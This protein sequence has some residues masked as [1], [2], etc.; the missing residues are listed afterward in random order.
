MRPLALLLLALLI[1]TGCHTVPPEPLVHLQRDDLELAI[2][3][4]GGGRA[5]S[6][7]LAGGANILFAT[8]ATGMQMPGHADRD[9]GAVEVARYSDDELVLIDDPRHDA[10]RGQGAPGPA[11]GWA[12]YGGHVTWVA[13]QRAWW[14]RV[15][16]RPP[17]ERAPIWPPDP[18]TVFGAYAIVEQHPHSLVL[19]GPASPITGLQLRKTYELLGDDRVRVSVVATNIGDAPVSWG[20]W[21]NTRLPAVARAFIPASPEAATAAD[22]GI[23]VATINGLC[24]LDTRGAR[25]GDSR[26][27]STS[28]RLGLIAAFIG[29]RVFV[30]EWTVV[31][32]EAV[33]PGH[34]P[35]E[36]YQKVGDDD[37]I[38]ELEFHGA[39]RTLQPGEAMAISEIWSL[40][41][42]DGQAAP[43]DQ[44]RFLNSYIRDHYSNHADGEYDE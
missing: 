36:I 35:V 14:S 26:K 42:Y 15:S 39:Y 18:W 7:R 20:L 23:A 1:G 33:A 27:L 2:W 21:S 32:A 6:L 28:P 11:N 16:Y 31:A 4:G 24:F 3:P 12:A 40:L 8:A 30:K 5:V 17:R 38:L 37:G 19:I 13:P 41:R 43:T 34:A 10:H 22:D 29:D 44:V 9:D 25:A